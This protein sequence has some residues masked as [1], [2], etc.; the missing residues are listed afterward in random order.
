M[1]HVPDLGPELRFENGCLHRPQWQVWLQRSRN[2]QQK[3]PHCTAFEICSPTVV[4]CAASTRELIRRLASPHAAIVGALFPKYECRRRA[5][6]KTP[7][8]SPL[9][10]GGTT[11]IPPFQNPD[12]EA[13]H[14][15][16]GLPQLIPN[17]LLAIYLSS[18]Q[19]VPLWQKRK[20]HDLPAPLLQTVP[21]LDK[22]GLQGGFGTPGRSR[23]NDS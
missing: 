9:V 20:H 18:C 2:Q 7:L 5:S 6:I 8:Q 10:Q 15:T 4:A 12:L 1:L 22:G 17:F 16:V 21:P 13:H 19:L 23:F 11:L 3:C 14:T